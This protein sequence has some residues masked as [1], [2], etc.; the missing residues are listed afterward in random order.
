M[1]P[2][3]NA[4]PVHGD[5]PLDRK[6][7]ELPLPIYIEQEEINSLRK[8]NEELRQQIANLTYECSK[9]SALAMNIAGNNVKLRL[10]IVNLKRE[11]ET[12]KGWASC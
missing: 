5:Y 11:L 6:I 7:K 2:L 3:A 4:G 10:Q 12:L 9:K 1:K 8:E